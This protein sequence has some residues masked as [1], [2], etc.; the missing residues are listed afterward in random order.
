MFADDFNI[1]HS[2]PTVE[3]HLL[4]VQGIIDG[5][6]GRCLRNN[7]RTNTSETEV[8]SFSRGN[9]IALDCTERVDALLSIPRWIRLYNL[10]INHVSSTRTAA[11]RMFGIICRISKNF[12]DSL[13]H[14]YKSPVRSKSEFVWNTLSNTL[15]KQLDA[16]QKKFVR[17]MTTTVKGYAIMIV[18]VECQD[19]V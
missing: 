19:L 10:I 1:F 18:N 7:M 8:P 15:F 3:D 9:R 14:P 12:Q 17:Y 2:I 13:S 6:N 4:L 5:A 16:L 11:T